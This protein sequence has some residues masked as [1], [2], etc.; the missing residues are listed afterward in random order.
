MIFLSLIQNGT[1]KKSSV[2]KIE[3]WWFL[4]K[5]T[6]CN[7]CFEKKKN[8][9]II[10]PYNCTHYL[11]IDCHNK[12]NLR[13]IKCPSCRSCIHKS[14]FKTMIHQL[15]N[16]SSIQDYDSNLLDTDIYHRL[17]NLNL[18]TIELSQVILNISLDT[19]YNNSQLSA[20]QIHQQLLLNVT[21]NRHNFHSESIYQQLIEIINNCYSNVNNLN[22]DE[23]ELFNEYVGIYNN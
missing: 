18:S 21:N 23:L 9:H 7:I 4:H 13:S 1:K 19:L 20:T 14:F 16:D 3:K 15:N 10:N 22:I 2:A 17:L 8:K 12:W 5:K 11:C 6:L